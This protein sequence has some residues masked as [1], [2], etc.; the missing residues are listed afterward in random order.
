MSYVCAHNP[1]PSPGCPYCR[2][3]NWR[4]M[5]VPLAPA[6]CICPPTSEQTCQS[7]TCPRKSHYRGNT[8]GGTGGNTGGAA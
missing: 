4:T 1:C 8:W 7:P 6:G 2:P 5:P 3:E